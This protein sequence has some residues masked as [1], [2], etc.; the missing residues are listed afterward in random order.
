VS[1]LEAL[2][3]G[4]LQGV[5]EFLPVSSSGHLL[6]ARE[7]M[8]IR[9]IPLIFDVLLHLSTLLVVILVFRK[10]IM[11]LIVSFVRL[12]TGKETDSEDRGTILAII[13]ATVLTGIIGLGI[14]S[15]SPGEHPRLTGA[16]FCLTGI[17]LILPRRFSR[18]E[19]AAAPG[20]K[21]GLIVGIAQGL[22]V[23]PG[24]SRSGITITASQGAGL[25]REKSGEFAFLVS[26]PAILGALVLTLKEFEAMSGQ[27]SAIALAGGL[28]SSFA[29]GL[30][31]LLLLLKLVRRGRLYYFSFYLIPLGIITLL[32]V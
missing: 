19:G 18:Q 23:F 11:R 25:S 10:T 21:T 1:L 22:G 8:E 13:V 15:F 30:V 20:L 9:N 14:E 6:I 2:F 28:F 3:L 16:L 12:L 7:F 17:I 29:V 4:A 31:S 24:I 27:V 26:I 32:I 5:T